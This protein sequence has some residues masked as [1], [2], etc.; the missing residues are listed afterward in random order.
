[1][2]VQVL[3]RLLV[4]FQNF[5][6]L[7]FVTRSSNL[8]SNWNSKYIRIGSDWGGW[9]I[10]ISLYKSK[11]NSAT[12][13]SAG[14]AND[15]TF[16]IE[17]AKRSYNLIALDPMENSTN[18]ASEQLSNF[19]DVIILNL[20]LSDISGT[21]LFNLTHGDLSAA[22]NLANSPTQSLI[23]FKVISLNELKRKFPEKFDVEYLMLKMDIEGS[24]LE[25]LENFQ[26]N[27]MN[28]NLLAIELDFL[29]L[30]PFVNLH[31]RI[32]A[33]RKTLNII[34]KLKTLNYNL[35][36]YE[37]FN[38]YWENSIKSVRLGG[39]QE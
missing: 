5:L 34:E 21:K 36:Y 9:F 38:F 6:V 13:I 26:N 35:V 33:I 28:F 31:K 3:K 24:E 37:K 27:L 32:Q 30:I 25:I 16:D 12:V 14:I 22:R 23:P 17:I 15:T 8:D 18:Y 29:H 1:M 7:K 20:G 39:Q 11:L 2:L 4:A 19:Q 10:P